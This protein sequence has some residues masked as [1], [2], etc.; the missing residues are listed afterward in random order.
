MLP[1]A[2]ARE[3]FFSPFYF[4]FGFDPK[5]PLLSS[6][7][8]TIATQHTTYWTTRICTGKEGRVFRIRKKKKK[9]KQILVSLSF[10]LATVSTCF[11]VSVG[12]FFVSFYFGTFIWNL[13]KKVENNL[14]A[15]FFP[16]STLALQYTFT[17]DASSVP[18]FNC[19]IVRLFRSCGSFGS[20]GRC[21]CC[22]LADISDVVQPSLFPRHYSATSV[23]KKSGKRGIRKENQEGNNFFWFRVDISV[24][25]A[26]IEWKLFLQ[27][28]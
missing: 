28:K 4:L 13:K 5:Y 16:R 23:W 3:A 15:I 2:G 10:A 24:C 21:C 18:S 9:R 11:V 20:S 1:C 8:G 27:F 12:F 17:L 6:Q 19:C 14:I 26:A 22:S 7:Q 25:T